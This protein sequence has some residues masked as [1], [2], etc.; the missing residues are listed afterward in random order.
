MSRQ[1]TVPKKRNAGD[2]QTFHDPYILKIQV[3]PSAAPVDGEW[4][5]LTTIILD[6]TSR[7]YD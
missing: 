4:E 5:A 3:E 7:I 1:L 6:T 2:S